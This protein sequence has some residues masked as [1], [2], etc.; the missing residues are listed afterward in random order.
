MQKDWGPLWPRAFT[1]GV[2]SGNNPEPCGQVTL[3]RTGFPEAPSLERMEPPPERVV[4][5]QV[6][7][8]NKPGL[9]CSHSGF[10]LALWARDFPGP[11]AWAGIRNR[12]CQDDECLR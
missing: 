2:L 8:G 6:S 9:H 3:N 11:R 4:K 5:G 7:R 1:T 12:G 10:K